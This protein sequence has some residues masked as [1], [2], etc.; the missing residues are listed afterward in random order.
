MLAHDDDDKQQLEYAVGEPPEAVIL[1]FDS[2]WQLPSVSSEIAKNN[3][4][5]VSYKFLFVP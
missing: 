1:E 5:F 3:R 2:F 4:V